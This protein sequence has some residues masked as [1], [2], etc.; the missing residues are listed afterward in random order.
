MISKASFIFCVLLYSTISIALQQSQKDG[1]LI[2]NN[3]NFD[4]TLKD[5]A[6]VFVIFHNP[7]KELN[8]QI[9]QEF[10]AAASA[11][12]EE[13]HL[14]TFAKIDM[15]TEIEL[16]RKLL[17]REYPTLKLVTF[18]KPIE[19]DGNIT[20]SDIVSWIKANIKLPQ[21]LAN[22]SDF[23]K[24]LENNKA[25]VIFWGDKTMNEY[26]I[27]NYAAEGFKDLSIA[28]TTSKEVKEKYLHLENTLVSMFKQYDDQR[29]DYKGYVYHEGLKRFF[30]ANKTPLI[31]EFDP[32][33]TR[34]YFYANLPTII[35]IVSDNKESEK[36]IDALN[37]V[38]LEFKGKAYMT[39]K[40]VTDKW[41]KELIQTFRNSEEDLPLLAVVRPT[42]RGLPVKY[43]LDDTYISEKVILQFYQDCIDGTELPYFK[44][45]PVPK[46]NNETVKIV[47]GK[48][49]NNIV[50]DETKN[51]FVFFYANWSKLCAQFLQTWE[52]L[53]EKVQS[54]ENLV[55]AK[56]DIYANEAEGFDIEN[57]PTLLLFPKNKTRIEKYFGP[58]DVDS[59]LRWLEPRITD[60]QESQIDQEQEEERNL[61]NGIQE[62][63]DYRDREKEIRDTQIILQ[64]EKEEDI[65]DSGYDQINQDN[66]ETEIEKSPQ[67]ESE[68]K[69]SDSLIQGQ[70]KE[71]KNQV[72]E[73]VKDELIK[74]I[75]IDL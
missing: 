8:K 63:I 23:E 74:K 46:E 14:V 50:K 9:L 32:E 41:G 55:I 25:L 75:N 6:Y 26:T 60:V 40:K 73:N 18:G 44:S 1:I 16:A 68:D 13:D 35:L 64:D 24:A 61:E 49:F 71:G 28:Y 54:N 48:T 53:A 59:I 70:N 57:V 33:D 34:K 22:L 19:Y 11:L 66:I 62:G 69:T 65:E 27:L 17:I 31:V 10:V 38:K 4:E 58:K 36:A 12:K 5:L 15:S 72:D 56:M 3:A 67:H 42:R 30:N 45:E 39:T 47:V 37:S 52:A 43:L 51:V 21:F 29:V 7:E 2:I 20:K